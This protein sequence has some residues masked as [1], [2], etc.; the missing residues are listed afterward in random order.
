MTWLYAC[1][2]VCVISELCRG[3]R[4]GGG[5][6]CTVNK[7]QQQ[8]QLRWLPPSLSYVVIRSGWKCGTT[9]PLTITK[10]FSQAEDYRQKLNVVCMLSPRSCM[11]HV[12]A[13]PWARQSSGC[14]PLPA[15]VWGS[16][17]QMGDMVTFKPLE[18]LTP[19]AFYMRASVIPPSSSLCCLPQVGHDTDTGT[20][21]SPQ[22]AAQR[23]HASVA[24][25]T[26]LLVSFLTS[27][28]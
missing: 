21:L 12:A 8:Q 28:K 27:F 13:P 24:L 4:G 17:T 2:R 14:S 16:A 15:A 6:L 20:P 9:L 7:Q 22:T 23:G 3:W 1:E 18:W 10:R 19:S 5:G 11:P 26:H 25:V